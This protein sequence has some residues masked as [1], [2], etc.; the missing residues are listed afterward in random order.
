MEIKIIALSYKILDNFTLIIF[1]KILLITFNERNTG[2][3]QVTNMT[4]HFQ[5]SL[6]FKNSSIVLNNMTAKCSSN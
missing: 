1:S 2:V 4:F 3:T 5:I 6:N